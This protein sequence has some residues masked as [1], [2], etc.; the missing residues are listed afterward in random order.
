MRS[1]GRRLL[2]SIAVALSACGSPRPAE[3]DAY[4]PPQEDAGLPAACG[5]I[6]T[7][8]FGATEGRSFRPLDLQR[9]DGT[10]WSF[11]AESE[12][13]CDARYTVLIAA[14]GWCEPCRIEA[15]Q[16][17]AELVDRYG[18]MGVRVVTVLIQDESFAAP[19]QAFC[20]AWRDEFSL[21]HTLVMDPSQ[22]TMIYFPDMALPAN[23][24]VDENG[25]IVHREYGTSTG[26][27]SIRAELDSLLAE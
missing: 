12:G 26:L 13:Y 10:P 16:V 24:I 6:P 19:E 8:D 27:R 4:V 14:A 1:S 5:A 2:V 21:T 11:Y 22:R 15:A 9:C 20:E 25:I 23:L 18:P 17:E 7:T 3:V